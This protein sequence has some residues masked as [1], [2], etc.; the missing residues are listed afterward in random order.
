MRARRRVGTTETQKKEL[1]VWLDPDAQ[2][3]LRSNAVEPEREPRT[4]RF[5]S[6]NRKTLPRRDESEAGRV[7]DAPSSVNG[8]G[9]VGRADVGSRSRRGEQPSCIE[10]RPGI[11]LDVSDRDWIDRGRGRLART[12]GSVT[13]NGL[14]G[15]RVRMGLKRHA[16]SRRGSFLS[17]SEHGR[18]LTAGTGRTVRAEPQS[19]ERDQCSCNASR[20]GSSP[21]AH[22]GVPQSRFPAWRD[23]APPEARSLGGKNTSPGY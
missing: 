11:N 14:V 4:Q 20:Q 8:G 3:R 17:A 13:G 19:Q 16:V 5:T 9:R 18:I 2:S 6:G 23:N 21:G 15:N 22:H 12:R 1:P 10:E 7:V